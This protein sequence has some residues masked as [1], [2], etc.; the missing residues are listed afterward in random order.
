MDKLQAKI[1]SE[2]RVLIDAIT[3]EHIIAR[4]QADAPEIDGLVYLPPN[5][6][7]KVGDF[8][9][10]RITESDDYDLYGTPITQR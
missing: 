9:T 3:D 1:G 4:S 5:Q 2:Q 10:V 7:L 8:S 6:I